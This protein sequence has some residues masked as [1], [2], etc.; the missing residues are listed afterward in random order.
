LLVEDATN[1]GSHFLLNSLELNPFLQNMND[2]G[3]I[4]TVAYESDNSIRVFMNMEDLSLKMVMDSQQLGSVR[5]IE[6]LGFLNENQLNFV[7]RSEDLG[8]NLL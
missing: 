5:N 3:Y 8:I 2:L 7:I 6:E 4:G 1:I